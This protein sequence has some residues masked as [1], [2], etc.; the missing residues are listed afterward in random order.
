MTRRRLWL[1]AAWLISATI[2]VAVMAVFLFGCC[3]LP[4]HQ[5]IHHA[6]PLCGG[7]VR[8]L[9]GDHQPQTPSTAPPAPEKT[10][11]APVLLASMR[12]L[13]RQ[14]SASIAPPMRRTLREG[15][16]LGAVR[17]DQDVGLHVLHATFLI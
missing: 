3:V 2:P 16:C 5:Y 1:I 12:A 14:S 7:I 13:A 4:F 17:C 11:S 6:L 9:A 10:K 8:M 15:L